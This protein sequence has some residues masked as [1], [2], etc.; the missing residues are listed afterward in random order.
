MSNGGDKDYIEIR[1]DFDT[2]VD[3]CF[4][5]VDVDRSNNNWEDTVEVVGSNDGT[6]VPLGSSDF[7]LYGT[8]VSYLGTNT[9]RGV[10]SVGGSSNAANADVR[11]P[12]PVDQVVITY[13][14]VSKWKTTQ[15]VGIHDLRWC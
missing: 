3:L 1:I 10:Y 15:F 6:S 8:G 5:L 12:E 7:F 14:D 11:F 13:S 4:T 2:P 9:V